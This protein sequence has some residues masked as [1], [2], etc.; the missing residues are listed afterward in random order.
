MAEAMM[1]CQTRQD[2][3][4]VLAGHLERHF[5]GLATYA[6]E[7]ELVGFEDSFGETRLARSPEF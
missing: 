4:K 2:F 7:A 5:A 3:V 1:G 6:E